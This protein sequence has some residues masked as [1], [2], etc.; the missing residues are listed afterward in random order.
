MNAAQLIKKAKK[1]GFS[2]RAL[3]I[4][5]GKDPSYL[6]SMSRREVDLDDAIVKRAEAILRGEHAPAWTFANDKIVGERVSESVQEAGGVG[7]IVDA[8]GVS[9]DVIYKWCQGKASPR[10]EETAKR[11]AEVL[12]VSV[13][14]LYGYGDKAGK[15]TQRK[16]V[17]PNVVSLQREVTAKSNDLLNERTKARQRFVNVTL[18]AEAFHKVKEII[19]TL[20]ADFVAREL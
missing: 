7:A 10:S 4:S 16:P 19:G 11:L 20:D 13:D 2:A 14:F 3:S 17:A 15:E 5:L 9:R 18:T 6:S 8:V 1:A 12:G